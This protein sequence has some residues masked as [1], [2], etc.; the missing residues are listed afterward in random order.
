MT[1]TFHRLVPR[2]TFFSFCWF[3]KSWSTLTQN[4]L[5]FLYLKYLCFE[6]FFL[7][8]LSSQLQ[9]LLQR[10]HSDASHIPNSIP[11]QWEISKSQ[12]LFSWRTVLPADTPDQ[13][14]TERGGDSVLLRVLQRLSSPTTSS[15][16]FSSDQPGCSESQSAATSLK[17]RRKKEWMLSEARSSSIK[18]HGQL[19]RNH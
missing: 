9:F 1:G 19:G 12:S 16:T 14:K 8:T 4:W 17:Q 6:T 3:V 13:R 11:S 18:A 5:K 2:L 15:H 10:E 7:W